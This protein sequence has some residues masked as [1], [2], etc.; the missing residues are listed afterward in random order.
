EPQFE[1]TK[2]ELVGIAKNDEDVLSY[3]AFP[4]VAERFFEARKER[5]EKKV[6]YTIEKVED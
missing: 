6:S 5:E 1:K 2:A 3:I 4:Q